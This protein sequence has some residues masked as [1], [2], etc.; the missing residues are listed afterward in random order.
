M[1]MYGADSPVQRAVVWR[2]LRHVFVFSV[3]FQFL[4][5][6][7]FLGADSLVPCVVVWRD[8][9]HNMLLGSLTRASVGTYLE[10]R[11]RRK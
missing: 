5:I 11:Y 8:L 3:Q 10:S 9:R 1:G 7:W 2:D 4:G 6:F